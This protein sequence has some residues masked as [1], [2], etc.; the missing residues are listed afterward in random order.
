MII[1]H[2]RREYIA[3]QVG[4]LGKAILTVGLAS[5]FFEKF[6]LGV[7]ISLSCSGVIFLVMGVFIQPRKQGE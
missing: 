1:E 4:D 2:S 7:R 6:P 3:R 5:Y